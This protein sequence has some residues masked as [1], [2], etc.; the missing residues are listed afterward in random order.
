MAPSGLE[1]RML[2]APTVFSCL[3]AV[4]VVF[5]VIF[6]IMFIII[7]LL[8]YY[9]YCLDKEESMGDLIIYIFGGFRI[10]GRIG[11]IIKDDRA[12]N[13]KKHNKKITT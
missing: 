13:N 12:M 3:R 11:V 1:V 10:I 9:F 7:L 2:R 6:I 5:L 8:L 4:K